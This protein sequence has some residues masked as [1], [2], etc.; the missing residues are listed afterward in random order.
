MT[1][2]AHHK[3]IVR[4][5]SASRGVYCSDLRIEKLLKSLTARR[6][7]MTRY[8]IF[9]V[10]ALIFMGLSFSVIPAVPTKQ[11]VANNVPAQIEEIP[12]GRPVM[13][14][15][16]F[17]LESRDLFFGIGGRKGEPDPSARYTFIKRDTSGHSEKIVV[18]DNRD[19]R[20]TIKFGP[21]ARPETTSSRIVWAAGYHVDQDY[22]VKRAHVEGRGGFDVWDV[23]F[24]RDNDGYKKVDRWSWQ[25][26]PFLGTREF[27]GLK[28]LMALL[29]NFDLKTQNN[30][31]VRPGK[32]KASEES[33]LIYYVNDLGATLGSTGAWYTNAP[34]L[35]E[36]PTGTKGNAKHYSA[37]K[38]IDEVND[39]K[40]VLH[41]ARSRAKRAMSPV[42]IE[43]AR[44]I[45][46]VLARISDRQLSDAFRAGGFDDKETA[47]YI[48]TIKRRIKLLQE[49]K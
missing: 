36:I 31:V 15:E 33:K 32:K 20:W 2:D 14:E 48:R 46:N 19:R 26:N 18:E 1:P 35:G 44:W 17:D 11:P 8:T 3:L 29:N 43:N 45:A 13:W 12:E 21:E 10:N 25:N 38:F 4:L 41:S 30:K 22:F 6:I 9:F 47:I 42:S 34:I 5:G 37:S 7:V 39:G 16:P 27:D 24:E 49:L 23:R 40:I 28:V